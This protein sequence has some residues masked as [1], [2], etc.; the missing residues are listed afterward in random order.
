M[1]EEVVQQVPYGAGQQQQP[2]A[3]EQRNDPMVA[4][5]GED[6]QSEDE[7]PKVCERCDDFAQLAAEYRAKYKAE[8]GRRILSELDSEKLVQ[9]IHILREDNLELAARDVDLSELLRNAVHGRDEYKLAVLTA[10]K[11]FEIA[12]KSLGP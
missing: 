6:E 3:V 10:M 5:D 7:V 9:Q 4:E 11:D 8:K 1:S 12:A 2:E